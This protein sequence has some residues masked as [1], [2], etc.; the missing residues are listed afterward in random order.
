MAEMKE[1]VLLSCLV[2]PLTSSHTHILSFNLTI[3]LCSTFTEGFIVMPE[4]VL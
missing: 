1:M 3:N 4:T 2:G